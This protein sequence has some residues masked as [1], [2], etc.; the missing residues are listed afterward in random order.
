MTQRVEAPKQCQ[1]KLEKSGYCS[2]F[3]VLAKFGRGDWFRL[4]ANVPQ[5]DAEALL[6][7]LR[8]G[9]EELGHHRAPCACGEVLLAPGEVLEEHAGGLMPGEIFE[10]HA[11]DGCT[12]SEVPDDREWTAEDQAADEGMQQAIAKAEK[13][14]ERRIGGGK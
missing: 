12:S 2:L 4:I 8:K 10:R 14:N 9:A 13:I 3:H 5:V 7:M 6:E 1:F 11:E